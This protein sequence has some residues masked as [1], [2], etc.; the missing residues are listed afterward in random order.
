MIYHYCS[1]NNFLNIIESKELWLFNINKMNDYMESK[2]IT[3]MINEEIEKYQ[4]KYPKF[5]EQFITNY[6]I[7]SPVPYIFCFSKE[8]DILSQWRSYANDG[9]GV[10]IGFDEEKF[11]I[12]NRP[13]EKKFPVTAVCETIS[14]SIV[15]CIYDTTLQKKTISDLFSKTIESTC[16]ESDT[17]NNITN[18]VFILNGYSYIMK[19][20]AFSEEKEVRIIHLPL[21]TQS[22][23]DSSINYIGN[24]SEIYFKPKGDTISS[25]FKYELKDFFDSTLIPEIILGPECKLDA[26]DLKLFL[27]KNKLN[28]TKIIRS[29]ASYRNL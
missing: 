13:L 26:F 7:N 29:K 14:T 3:P 20:D 19:N 11:K 5:I 6:S 15:P 1:V 21:I 25:Y 17:F 16:H 24:L 8:K 27:V 22:N 18:L 4:S 28:S 23:K 10:A 9:K 2:W 12:K